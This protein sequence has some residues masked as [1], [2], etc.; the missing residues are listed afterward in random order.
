MTTNRKPPPKA[1]TKQEI[2]E[3]HIAAISKV[4]GC[5]P[6]LGSIRAALEH[7]LAVTALTRQHLGLEAT[8]HLSL[9]GMPRA[10]ERLREAT[11]LEASIQ[12]VLRQYKFRRA[13]VVLSI[14][15][16]SRSPGTG[17]EV[18]ISARE[19]AEL[20]PRSFSPF[21]DIIHKQELKTAL[22]ET[23]TASTMTAAVSGLKR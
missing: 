1:K 13:D 18:S 20:P 8:P 15:F 14:A 9:E 21:V 2:D 11:A 3:E 19:R 12:E 6:N 17:Y 22:L 23:N 4:L 5:N 10:V 7:K 16:D